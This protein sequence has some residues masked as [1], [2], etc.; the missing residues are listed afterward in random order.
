MMFGYTLFSFLVYTLPHI[1]MKLTRLIV[2]L[3]LFLISKIL[4]HMTTMMPGGSLKRIKNNTSQKD[5]T[6][7]FLIVLTLHIRNEPMLFL[8]IKG[9]VIIL[10]IP[11]I[12]LVQYNKSISLL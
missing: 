1:N 4:T 6:A 2:F 10:S 3:L 8:S 9:W 7:R 11:V 5:V 12:R